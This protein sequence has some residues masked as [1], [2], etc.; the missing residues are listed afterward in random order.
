[1]DT[2]G[3][4]IHILEAGLVCWRPYIRSQRV[5]LHSAAL[6]FDAVR[7]I[8]IGMRARNYRLITSTGTEVLED[9]DTY[10]AF[11]TS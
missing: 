1:M 8:V 5:G 6:Q 2:S 7:S 9:I 10:G 3:L 11:C 4:T